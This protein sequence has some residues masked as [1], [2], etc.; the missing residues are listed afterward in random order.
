V[1][2]A[3]SPTPQPSWSLPA[4]PAGVQACDAIKK[5]NAVNPFKIG[6][7]RALAVA[8]DGSRSSKWAVSSV[9][10]DLRVAA[11]TLKRSGTPTDP[12]MN[13]AVG[14]AAMNLETACI[15]NGYYPPGS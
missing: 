1:P 5:L 7:D 11:A 10:E 9:A 6:A 12:A 15:K 3:A 2:T 14:T 8:D 13:L 4:D